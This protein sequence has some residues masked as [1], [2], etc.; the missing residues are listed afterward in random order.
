M[1]TYRHVTLNALKGTKNLED[2]LTVFNVSKTMDLTMTKTEREE[3]EERFFIDIEPGMPDNTFGDL[4]EH[5]KNEGT[6]FDKED[7]RRL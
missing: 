3:L 4:L 1:I 6:L 2:I 7:L 5:F